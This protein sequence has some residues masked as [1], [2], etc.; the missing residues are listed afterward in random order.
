MPAPTAMHSAIET[1]L[2]DLLSGIN[3][4]AFPNSYNYTPQ[5]VARVEEFN[6]D[7]LRDEMATVYLLRP[8]HETET[9]RSTCA[10]FRRA[11]FFVLGARKWQ[12]ASTNPHRENLP[13]SEVQSRLEEDL[14]TCLL[15][16][17]SL[18]GLTYDVQL[19]DT[20]YEFDVEGSFQWAVVEVRLVADYVYRKRVVA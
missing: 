14:K 3:A 7:Y 10:F 6:V 12:E 11:E 15:Q 1:K 16:D 9:K 20:E 8:G 18:G 4:V 17:F 2:F 19:T 5:G 13:R